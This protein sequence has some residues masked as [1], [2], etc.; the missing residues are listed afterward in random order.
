MH[1]DLFNLARSLAESDNRRARQASLRRAVA[2]DYYAMFHFLVDEVC[3]TQIGTQISQKKYRC[4]LARAFVR[5]S[6]KEA[7]M[8]FASSGCSADSRVGCS[9]F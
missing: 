4:L 7:C 3:C 9:S 6:V 8:S 2:T 1:S 5:T